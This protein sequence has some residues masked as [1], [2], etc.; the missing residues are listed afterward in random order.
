MVEFIGDPVVLFVGKFSNYKFNLRHIWIFRLSMFLEEFLVG[1]A[2]QG[3]Y[4][5]YINY[6]TSWHRIVHPDLGNFL[7][8]FSPNQSEQ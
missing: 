8:F 4:L 2:F 5:F 1:Y 7:F 3:I 6:G